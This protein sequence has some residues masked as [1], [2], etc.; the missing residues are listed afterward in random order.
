MQPLELAKMLLR[1]SHE[2]LL[3][4]DKLFEE[5]FQ[6]WFIEILPN[7]RCEAYSRI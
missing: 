5:D 3:A 2:L 6:T 1:P 4:N 7:Q